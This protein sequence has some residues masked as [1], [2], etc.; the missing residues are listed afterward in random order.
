MKKLVSVVFIFVCCFN[1]PAQNSENAGEKGVRDTKPVR[2]LVMENWDES[3]K[4]PNFSALLGGFQD[5][6]YVDAKT[7]ST[8]PNFGSFTPFSLEGPNE[9][10]TRITKLNNEMGDVCEDFYGVETEESV[11]SGVFISSDVSWNPMPRIPVS[12]SPNNTVY[13]KIVRDFL[14]TKGIANPFVK[15]QQ[16]YKVDL[17]GDG[18]DEVIIRATNYKGGLNPSTKAGDYSFVMVRRISSKPIYGRP[19]VKKD[20]SLLLP[21]INKENVENILIAGE[22]YPKAAEFN[23]PSEYNLTAMLDLNA[24]GKMELVVYGAYYEGAWVEAYELLKG[25]KPKI[26]LETGCGV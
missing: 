6:K 14:R 10:E 19:G 13:V 17:E 12:L 15:I 25:A 21:K 11:T 5:G 1:A 9:G 3:E 4:R 16:I 20:G 2:F 8:F 22:F 26:V 24:D 7:A 18:T 23:A